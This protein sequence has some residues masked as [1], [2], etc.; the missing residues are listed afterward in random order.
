MGS[1][2]D[3]NVIRRTTVDAD[4][5]ETLPNERMQE[6][7][8]DNLDRSMDF[9]TCSPPVSSP[10]V[11]QPIVS[12]SGPRTSVVMGEVMLKRLGGFCQSGSRRWIWK[13]W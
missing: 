5:S 11:E 4:I 12:C 13:R 10:L 7:S 1:V 2:T 8:V 9:I 6:E 3:T